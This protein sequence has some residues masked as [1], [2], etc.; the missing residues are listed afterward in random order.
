MDRRSEVTPEIKK[1]QE[2]GR[3]AEDWKNATEE[4]DRTGD[5]TSVRRGGERVKEPA[6]GGDEPDRNIIVQ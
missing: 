5:L 4:A 2:P 6:A 1:E 3:A